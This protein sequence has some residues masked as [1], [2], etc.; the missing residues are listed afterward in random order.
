MS[1]N[2]F[3]NWV[4]NR[5]LK[6]GKHD[7]STHGNRYGVNRSEAGALVAQTD[8]PEGGYSY[9]HGKG[10]PTTGYT[11]SL[12][13][14]SDVM[15]AKDLTAE[16]IMAFA[17]RWRKVLKTHP[18]AFLGGWFDSGKVYLD[19]SE[20]YPDK[21]TALAKAEERGELGIYDVV[22]G[23]TIYTSHAK[24]EKT[25]GTPG[26]KVRILFGPE[27]TDEE[28]VNAMLKLRDELLEPDQTQETQAKTTDTQ[29]KS[30]EESPK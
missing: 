7:Q 11:V 6:H 3:V 18:Q 14:Y 10:S 5:A 16:R 8:H 22:N 2:E 23:V 17:K 15:D 4:M 24:K 13:G 29:A 28:I 26:K 9:R 21:E 12:P 27:A 19:I 30:G 20:N 25:M 1:E